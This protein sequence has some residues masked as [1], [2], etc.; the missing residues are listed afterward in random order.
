MRRPAHRN[1]PLAQ[2]VDRAASRRK[3]R[4]LLDHRPRQGNQLLTQYS[5]LSFV[6]GTFMNL[7][8]LHVHSSKS[9][10]TLTPTELTAHAAAA[11]LRAYALTDHDNTDGLE[12]ALTASARY[13]IEVI[14]G[15]EFSTEYFGKDIHIIG[16]EAD[17]SH[18]DFAAQIRFYR[19][20]RFRRNLKMIQRM[21]D[22]GIDISFEQMTSSFGKT[23]WTRAH[24]ARYLMDHGYVSRM[25]DAFRIYIGE[26]CR[27]FVP[28]EKVS[29]FKVTEQLRQYH[30]IPILAHPLL[31]HLSDEELRRLIVQ[32]KEKGLIGIEVYYSLH[33]KEEEAYLMALAQEYSLLPS[34]GSDFHGSNK[35]DTLIG[36]GHGNLQIPYSILENLRRHKIPS[37]F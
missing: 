30:G 34:G 31:Y 37:E 27:Y 35:P 22:D 11:G 23:V 19:D 2:H 1:Q 5:G 33:S 13:G 24:F 14:P 28:R 18:P 9:D 16:L 32:L 25:D 3:E 10:G 12:E 36:T 7:I 4:L 29:P 6:G 8:D 26:D 20:E 21:A 17:F 15:I